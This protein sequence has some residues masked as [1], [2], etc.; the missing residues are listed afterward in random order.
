[1]AAPAQLRCPRP[2]CQEPIR[3][4]DRFCEACGHALTSAVAN[5]GVLAAAGVFAP[6]GNGTRTPDE[7]DHVEIAFEDFAGVSDRGLKRRRN[8][9]SM[10]LAKVEEQDAR[11]LVVCDGVATSS[12]PVLAS[13]AAAET[14]KDYLLD[15]VK[16]GHEDLEAAMGEAV[17]AAQ[18]AVSVVPYTRSATNDPPAT[19][20]VGALLTRGR[21]TIGWVG[22][23]R[24]YFVGDSEAWQLSQDDSW[25]T[26]QIQLGLMSEQEASADPR[27][28]A[29]TSWLG[30]DVEAGAQVSV[31]TFTVPAS[32][33]I[34]LCS[35]GL[36]NCAPSAAEMRDLVTQ[37]P[38]DV[39]PLVV[40]QG[41]TDF[42]RSL[43]GNDN[44]TVAV[45]FV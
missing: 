32:G 7:R 40:A 29:L 41:L 9:D 3:P 36:W 15:A 31:S 20:F 25:A 22:D 5:A 28:H 17:A 39:T 34:L 23:S 24:A 11:I 16:A 8:E 27:A 37:F 4:E 21:A 10:A 42:A 38:A 1:M 6:A 13:T 2:S 44:I 14:A 19:T 45:A 33:C 26:E 12:E 18:R 35:D 43:G 30:G